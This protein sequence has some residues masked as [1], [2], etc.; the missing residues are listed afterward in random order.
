V[1]S[2]GHRAV[3]L[4]NLKS[5]AVLKMKCHKW[6]GVSIDMESLIDN[7]DVYI[8]MG[9]C[10][11][12]LEL[13]KFLCMYLSGLKQCAAL[14]RNLNS[15]LFIYWNYSLSL[16]CNLNVLTCL[17]N[18]DDP[19]FFVFFIPCI[20]DNQITKYSVQQ[21]WT[22]CFQMDWFTVYYNIEYQKAIGA[23]LLN[24]MLCN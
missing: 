12:G 17:R 22:Y 21:K 6:V 19:W 24:W 7:G 3:M 4:V 13:F 15:F 14:F 11:A 18:R 1:N 8:S 9:D 20:V 23:F 2:H 5:H 10:I 16:K